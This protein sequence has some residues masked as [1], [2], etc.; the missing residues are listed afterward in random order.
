MQILPPN[1]LY[2][3]LLFLATFASLLVSLVSFLRCKKVPCAKFMALY[4]LTNVIWSFTYALHWTSIFRPNEFFW[5]DMT[6]FGVAFVA[7]T[8]L[9]FALCYAGWH[10]YLTKKNFIFLSIIPIFTLFC[11]IT[12]S[13]LGLFFA[14]K[15]VSGSSVIFD[16]GIGFWVFTAYSYTLVFLSALIVLQAIFR[17]PKKY[18][19]QASTVFFGVFSPV[20][21]NGLSFFD[22]FPLP[23][24]PDANFLRYHRRLFCS[25]SV[26]A[27]IS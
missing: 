25:C 26:A 10:Q 6:Y 2:S 27:R 1:R 5:V 17:F 15:R 12:D 8:F 21:I 11:L 24:R 14:G 18:Q 9:A 3:T 19:G 16:G 22:I 13:S 20:F 7:I 23:D 4:G